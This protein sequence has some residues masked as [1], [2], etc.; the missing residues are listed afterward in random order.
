MSRHQ[1]ATTRKTKLSS[2][3]QMS[4]ESRS[5]TTV[6]V[7]S[8]NIQNKTHL[9]EFIGLQLLADDFARN[10]FWTVMPDILNGDPRQTLNDPNF[11]AAEW[12]AKHGPDSWKPV[13]DKVVEAL[14]AQGVTRI[15][16]TGYCF[17]A[18]PAFYLALKHESHVTVLSH[19]SRLVY[20][21]DLEV[22][23]WSFAPHSG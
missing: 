3:S 14:K 1:R 4:L 15:G 23:L 7:S 6:Y 16:T 13:V 12:I 11:D 22:C 17:G 20:P 5:S 2:S 19:P 8:V 10:G 21:D 18:P 9:I